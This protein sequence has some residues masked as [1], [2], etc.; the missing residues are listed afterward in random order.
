LDRLAARGT[1][2]IAMKNA[3]LDIQTL[4]TVQLRAVFEKLMPKEL[5]SRGISNAPVTCEAVMA[6]IAR[7]AAS[8]ESARSTSSDEILKRLGES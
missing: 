8:A 1:L 4:T 5:E 6:A 2:R 7:G 3:G